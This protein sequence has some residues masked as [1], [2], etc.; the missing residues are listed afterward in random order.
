MTGTFWNQSTTDVKVATL[1]ATYLWILAATLLVCGVVFASMNL[2][3]NLFC[4]LSSIGVFAA[5]VGEPNII[6]AV[7]ICKFISVL[8][9]L[10][11]R[12]SKTK[13]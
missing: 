2:S 3:N 5:V 7:S 1:W 6:A 10:L 12:W 4:T 8:S 11:S 13:E 9:V